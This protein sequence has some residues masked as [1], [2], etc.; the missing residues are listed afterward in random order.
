MSTNAWKGIKYPNTN[1]LLLLL[2][3]NGNAIGAME[4]R[5]KAYEKLVLL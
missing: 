4:R 1:G 3:S 2:L 5:Y